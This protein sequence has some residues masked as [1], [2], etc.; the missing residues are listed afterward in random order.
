MYQVEAAN[1]RPLSDE[2]LHQG[3]NAAGLGDLFQP[4]GEFG[5]EHQRNSRREVHAGVQHDRE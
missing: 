1:G 5:A 3:L 2:E 4:V